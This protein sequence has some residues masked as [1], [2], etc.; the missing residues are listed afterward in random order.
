MFAGFLCSSH[1][2]AQLPALCPLLSSE[3]G[4]GS[5][6]CSPGHLSIPRCFTPVESASEV[7]GRDWGAGLNLSHLP[8]LSQGFLAVGKPVTT[9]QLGKEHCR[10]ERCRAAGE[11]ECRAPGEGASAPGCEVAGG[12]GR[13]LSLPVRTCSQGLAC[14]QV[15]L[16]R[17][18]E[19]TTAPRVRWWEKAGRA[20]ALKWGLKRG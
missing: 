12:G 10:A 1:G 7:P 3:R 11:P 14:G 15:S 19:A 20:L 5:S 13:R 6:A 17:G 16:S 2:P 9:G 4:G 18:A 8:V